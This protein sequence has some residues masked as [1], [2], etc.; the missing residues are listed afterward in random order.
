MMDSENYDVI[1]QLMRKNSIIVYKN[2]R[3]VKRDRHIRVFISPC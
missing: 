1:Q 3:Y 2:L